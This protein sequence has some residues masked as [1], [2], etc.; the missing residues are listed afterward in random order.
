M[1]VHPK[2][3]RRDIRISAT[4]AERNEACQSISVAGESPGRVAYSDHPRLTPFLARSSALRAL[5]TINRPMAAPWQLTPELFSQRESLAIR[6]SV[7]DRLVNRGPEICA[8]IDH[9][10]IQRSL[11]HEYP[12]HVLRR[13]RSRSALAA[14]PAEPSGHRCQIVASGDDSHAETP[15]SVI[16]EAGKEAGHP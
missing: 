12:D 7:V 4:V 2:P 11:G 13:V 3:R 14:V 15:A 5:T 9:G 8:E 16:P 1:P 6:Q 10:R